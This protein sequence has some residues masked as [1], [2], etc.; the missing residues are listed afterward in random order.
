MEHNHFFPPHTGVTLAA[1]A[2]HTG[3]ELQD[4]S[5]GERIVRSVSPVARAKDGD[6]CY[7]LSRRNREELTTCQA[8]AIFCEKPLAIS[9]EL[10]EQ[11]AQVRQL[12]APPIAH[13][14]GPMSLP[15]AASPEAMEDLKRILEGRSAFYSKADLS[16]DTSAQDADESFK[17]LKMEVRKVIQWV[18]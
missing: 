18:E 1:L 6:V 16:I 4:E 7:I 14:L 8:T 5:H 13:Y 11:M 15:M 9:T 17:R 10:A 2:A 12:D 3:A